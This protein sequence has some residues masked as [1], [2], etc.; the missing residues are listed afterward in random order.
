[1][2]HI[3]IH[4]HLAWDL[5]DGIPSIESC[6]KLLIEAQKDQITKI[7]ATPHF[8]CGKHKES[9]IE[10]YKKRI[11]ELKE[12]SKD[13]SI[14]IY[15]G[16]ELFINDL[17]FQYIQ[18][19][20]IIPF[21]NT[22]YV[23]CEFDVRKCY[24]DDYD[25]I[26]DA[27]Y[28]LVVAGYTPILAHVERYFDKKIDI[29]AIQNLIEIG[30]VIQ[31]NTSSILN[32]RDSVMKKN[33]AALLEHNLIHV[34]ATDS[35]NYKGKRSPNMSDTLT[36]LSNTYDVSNLEILFYHNPLAIISNEQVSATQFIKRRHGIRRFFK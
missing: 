3:D 31:V 1:M 25:Y 15:Q 26:Y 22:R 10:V 19:R 33:I 17:F 4:S 23:L 9:D 32:P 24:D 28:E 7:V 12:I 29:C 8:V 18:E 5:D 13:Y 36:H 20:I 35:H 6:K 14:E 16:S 30:C 2:K 11:D 27:L 21:E 34:I